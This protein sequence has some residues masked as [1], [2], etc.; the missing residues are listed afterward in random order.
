MPG[1]LWP[2]DRLAA[3]ARCLGGLRVA[4]AALVRAASAAVGAPVEVRPDVASALEAWCDAVEAADAV[5]PL[6]RLQLRRIAVEALVTG[7]RVE[8]S[9]SAGPRR[10]ILVVCGLPR[11]GT[12]LLHRLLSLAPDA[13]GVPFWQLLSPVP[14]PGRDTRR[15]SAERRLRALAAVSS[16]PLDAQHL[17]RADLPDECTHL[18]RPAFRSSFFWQVPLY[19]WLDHMISADPT[20]AYRAWHAALGVLEP[21][22]RRL[23]LKDPF[24]T[25]YLATLRAVAP[26]AM[27]VQTHRDPVETVPSFHRLCMTGHA[28]LCARLDVPRTVEAH[29]RWL[30]HHVSQ[31]RAARDTLPPGAICDVDYRALVADP[32]ATVARVHAQL[33]LPFDN[34]FEARI[35][36][37]IATHPQRAFGDNPYSAEDFGQTRGAIAERFS[38][39]RA[40]WN[41]EKPA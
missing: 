14:P 39:Y 30:E 36:E 13:S 9:N 2:L 7:H 12:T 34:V 35:A 11:S 4:P 5:R 37:W 38:A 21:P 17:I 40:A 8:R 10:P 26:D 41:L 29:M 22:D 18:F 27:I 15:L 20:P 33:G 24:H 1:W 25:G 6:A 28:A 3:L 19:G 23:V 32:I 31:N 16:V